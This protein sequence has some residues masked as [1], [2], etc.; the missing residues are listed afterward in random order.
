MDFLLRDG[1]A[2]L[3]NTVWVV[4][5]DLALYWSK[6]GVQFNRVMNAYTYFL[7]STPDTSLQLSCTTRFFPQLLV[8]EG[9]AALR[10]L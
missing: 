6:L 4:D 3:A 1:L 10:F 7:H 5:V 9:S 2:C 8:H